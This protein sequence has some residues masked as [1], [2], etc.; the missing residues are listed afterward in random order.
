MTR[1]PCQLRRTVLYATHMPR[2]FTLFAPLLAAL[3]AASGLRAAEPL[4]EVYRTAKEA[5]EAGDAKKCA[6]LLEARAADAQGDQRGALLFTLGVALLKLERP[7]DAEARLVEAA[8]L[9][10]GTPQHAAAWA[11]VGDARAAQDRP[12]DASAAYAE[13]TKAA[14]SEPDSSI[15]RYSAARIA[16]LEAAEFLLKGNALSAVGKFRVAAGRSPERAPI[17]QARIAEIAGNRKLRGEATAAAVFALGEIE[18]RA[19]HLPEA[20]AY[21]QRV[22]VSWLKYPAWVAP[23][24]LRAAECFD[25][26]GRRKE[27]I[28]HVREML[29]NAGRLKDRPELEEARRRLREWTPPAP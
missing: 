2:A 16:E 14:A 27:A 7:A 3:M 25:K 9:F 11:L 8:R 13:A 28:A 15:A 18:E 29:R 21:Y 23:A 12:G 19:G 1:K 6:A 5:L 10:A 24:Y 17:V 26:L 22:F 4:A 20:I